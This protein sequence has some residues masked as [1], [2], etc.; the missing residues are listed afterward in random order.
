MPALAPRD[1]LAYVEHL[2]ILAARSGDRAEAESVT[3]WLAER[4]AA[5]LRGRHL[6]AQARIAAELGDAE[7]AIDRLRGAL[8]RSGAY[9]AIRR[10][11]HLRRLRGRPDFE[12]VVTPA[13]P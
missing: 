11:Y 13:P 1:S 9:T 12:A 3:D 8:S 2:G 5:H 10:D 4:P 7:W 6:H